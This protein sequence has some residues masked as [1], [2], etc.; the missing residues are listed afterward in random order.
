VNATPGSSF[1]PLQE[2]EVPAAYGY[3]PR[4]AAQTAENA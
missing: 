2:R 4:P 3:A 1:P